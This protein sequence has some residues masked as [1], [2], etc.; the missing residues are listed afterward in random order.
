MDVKCTIKISSNPNKDV[1]QKIT[2]SMLLLLF[3]LENVQADQSS[4]KRSDNFDYLT[5]FML[6]NYMMRSELLKCYG[7]RHLY[8]NGSIR[9][10]VENIDF[11]KILRSK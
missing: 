10:S 3:R 8:S 7:K 5:H 6:L 9:P 1:K 4:K 2:G 11:F